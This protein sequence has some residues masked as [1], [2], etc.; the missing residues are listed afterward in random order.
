MHF[1]LNTKMENATSNELQ[2]FFEIHDAR[3]M[4]YWLALSE[5]S[6]KSYLQQLEKEERVRQLTS[7]Y[8]RQDG[9]VSALN[10]REGMYVTPEMELMTLAKPSKPVP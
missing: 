4:I 3:Y 7:V 8:A 6:Y 5:S 9:I 2:P 1:T 10:I